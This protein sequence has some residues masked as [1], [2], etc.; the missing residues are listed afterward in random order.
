M[1]AR[2]K[3]YVDKQ[4]ASWLG[5]CAG[6][7]NYTGIKVL[8][9]RVATVLLTLAGGFPWTLIAYLLTNMMAATKP[10]GMAR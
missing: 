10:A 1:S 5:V 2:S 7:A 3:F 6:I 4:N 8:W 9:V